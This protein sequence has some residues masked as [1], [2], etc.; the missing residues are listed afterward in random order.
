MKKL[1]LWFTTPFEYLPWW[2]T[3]LIGSVGGLMVGIALGA[4]L[5][6]AF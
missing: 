6:V 3:L 5:V 2:Q 4:F 1:W